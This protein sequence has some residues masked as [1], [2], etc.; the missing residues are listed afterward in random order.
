MV[1]MVYESTPRK[2]PKQTGV[3][4]RMPTNFIYLHPYLTDYHWNL[5]AQRVA[6]FGNE[7]CVNLL[8]S[9]CNCTLKVAPP[10]MF[11]I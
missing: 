2:V 3:V 6:N 4:G 9:Y 7:N 8:V 1:F 11:Q 10:Q 5:I